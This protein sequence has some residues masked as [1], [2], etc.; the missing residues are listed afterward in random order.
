MRSI[1]ELLFQTNRRRFLIG[2]LLGVTGSGSFL[3]LIGFTNRL[4]QPNA[5]VDITGIA[6]FIALTMTAALLMAMSQ[7]SLA[8]FGCEKAAE[9]RRNLVT[10]ILAT[11]HKDCEDVGAQRLYAALTDDLDAVSVAIWSLS[12]LVINVGVTVGGLAYLA[13]VSPPFFLCSIVI[14]AAGLMLSRMLMARMHANIRTGSVTEYKLHKHY[15]GLLQGGK[16]LRLDPA[17][18]KFFLHHELGR[19]IDDLKEHRVRSNLYLALGNAWSNV[20]LFL[21][22]GAVLT[23]G[24]TVL[25]ESVHVVAIYII[26]LLFLRNPI[27][28]I[29][30]L[31][32]VYFRGTIALDHLRQLGL[33][34]TH[35]ADLTVQ[36]AQ[37]SLHG[38]VTRLELDSVS[39]RHA[40]PDGAFALGPVSLTAEQGEIVFVSGGNG[41]GKT[42]LMKVVCGLY[43]PAGGRVLIDGREIHREDRDRVRLFSAV[44]NDSYVFDFLSPDGEQTPDAATV[45]RLL[46][47]QGLDALVRY[48]NGRLVHSGLSQGQQK[49]L[50]LVSVL[51]EDSPVVIF[52]EW[53]ANQD[54]HFKASFYEDVLERLRA[55]GK[56]VFVVT[57]D[58]TWFHKADRVVH[59]EDGRVVDTGKA[60]TGL[61]E[62]AALDG[63][64]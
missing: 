41:S 9:I 50:G 37:V 21:V 40:G 12:S 57:H 36:C 14:L 51:I 63:R 8:R 52:D 48:E 30:D 45:D 19:S 17:K 44:L 35:A 54:M 47:E 24:Y 33:R 28:T 46:R 6:L 4:L 22:I 58:T 32:P 64:V 16:E 55:A 53:A 43:E 11:S 31:T 62:I 2:T 15:E 56:I 39:Y 59:L 34:V 20:L 49:R 7:H 60:T 26:T 18:L 29:V 13:W 5:R 1:I 61:R 3:L 38:A 42:T 23:I 10:H 27:N 25:Q